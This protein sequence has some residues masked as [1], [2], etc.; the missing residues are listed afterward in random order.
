VDALV[1]ALARH[2]GVGPAGLSAANLLR[3]ST[4]VPRAA[5]IADARR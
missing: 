4:Q 3:L 1:D 2:E 5:Q